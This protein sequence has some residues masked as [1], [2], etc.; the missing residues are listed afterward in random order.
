M[1]FSI[2]FSFIGWRQ[3]QD[4]FSSK[5]LQVSLA[6]FGLFFYLIS[7]DGIVLTEKPIPSQFSFTQVWN[8]WHLK[9]TFTSA[10]TMR[11]FHVLRIPSW[12]WWWLAC[13]WGSVLF[14]TFWYWSQFELD[15]AKALIKLV[16]YFLH[17]SQFSSDIS[18]I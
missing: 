7:W 18:S 16:S 5:T 9:Y 10:F 3:W 6:D 12:Y 2:Q 17:S 8:S 1:W 14:M 15:F 4:V 11:C 13:G